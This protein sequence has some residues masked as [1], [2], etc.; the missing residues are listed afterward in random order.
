MRKLDEKV[1][2]ACFF[3]RALP[4]PSD[5][6]VHDAVV[7][8]QRAATA[9]QRYNEAASSL[10]LPKF[11]EELEENAKKAWRRFE[12]QIGHWVDMER[13]SDPRGCP[14]KLGHKYKSFGEFQVVGKGFSPSEWKHLN[15]LVIQ[16]EKERRR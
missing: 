10:D 14:I 16:Q 13:Q 12:I 3:C 9:I 15:E 4:S 5:T 8:A 7:A 6:E 2:L 11:V 1:M